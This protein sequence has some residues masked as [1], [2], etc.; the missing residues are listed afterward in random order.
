MRIILNGQQAFG[1]AALEKL[2]EAGTDEVV[3]VYCA[4]DKGSRTDPLREAALEHGLPL[5]Q[6]ASYSE[7]EVLEQ[8]KSHDADLMIMAFVTIFI[9]EAARDIP[10]MG[11]ICFHPS[12]LPLH[13][14]PAAINWAILH[15]REKTGFSWFYPTDGLDE[16]DLAYIWECPIDP[17]DTTGSLYFKKIIPRAVDS[18]LEVADLFRSG[19]P[20]R[21]EQDE[22]QATYESFC[23]A[24]DVAIDWS[25]DVDVTY[26]KIR[27]GNPQPGAGTSLN[28]TTVKIY[29]TARLDGI[30]TPGE[31]VSIDED[32]VTVQANGGRLKIMRVRPDGGDKQSASEWASSVGLKTG[33]KL[34]A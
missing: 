29:D 7:P 8:L 34:G 10:K 1:K 25:E 33:S 12:L 21:M 15:G 28:G 31:V 19:D 27:A 2:L 30:G 6:P 20:P 22:S 11:S 4:P 16:G 3:A 32:G 5:Y 23:K 17:D 26:R 18:G 14:G 13:R 24:P 9:P